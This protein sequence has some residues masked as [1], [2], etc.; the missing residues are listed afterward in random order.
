MW[1]DATVR[2]WNSCLCL[3]HLVLKPAK[4]LNE[5]NH[6]L[7]S[8][9]VPCIPWQFPLEII[10]FPQVNSRW[11]WYVIMF[12]WGVLKLACKSVKNVLTLATW[13]NQLQISIALTVISTFFHK[14]EAES[15]TATWSVCVFLR[16]KYVVK[17]LSLLSYV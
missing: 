14:T 11:N 17:K 12:H 16:N 13:W 5:T 4:M 7:V 10:H 15:Q 9:T 1:A 2:K 3:I 6:L 8:N